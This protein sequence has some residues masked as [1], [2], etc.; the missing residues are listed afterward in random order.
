MQHEGLQPALSAVLSGSRTRVVF[1]AGAL[2]RLG[3]LCAQHGASRVLL[4]TDPGIVAA[5]HAGCAQTFLEQAGLHVALFDG[6]AENPTTDHVDHG[7]QL[8]REMAIDFIVGLGGGSALDCAKGINFILTNG[9]RMHDYWGV[10]KA[11]QP[12]LASIGIPTTAGTGS[13][14]QSFAL[15]TDPV[16][17]QKMACGDTKAAF[18]VAILDPQLTRTCPRAVVAATGMDAISHAIETAATTRRNENSLALSR[19][20]WTLLDHSFERDLHHR[21]DDEAGADMLLGAHLAGAARGPPG[22]RRY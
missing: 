7:V 10:G 4:V 18:R 21:G 1:G 17:H 8:A 3:A 22:R 11:T 14:A 13:E 5:G 15:I 19:E 2:A 20:A 16:T 6:A 12:M 9:G